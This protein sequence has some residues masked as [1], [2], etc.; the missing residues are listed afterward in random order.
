MAK[1]DSKLDLLFSALSDPTRRDILTRLSF[2]TA[3]ITEL[4]EQHDMAL[5]SF[6]KHLNKLEEAGL[7]H[8]EKNGR[9]RTCALTPDAFI[10]MQ[11][12]LSEQRAVWEQRLNQFDRYALEL[13]RKR[14]NE[15]GSK[16]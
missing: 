12:W 1:Y 6:L 9:I 13:K 8:S 16:N 5:P 7:I 10:P 3:S 15:T 4:A 11:N 2:G 14:E